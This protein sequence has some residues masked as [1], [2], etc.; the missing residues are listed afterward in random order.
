MSASSS[1]SQGT[2]AP[3]S[4]VEYSS[5]GTSGVGTK[6]SSFFDEL[7]EL[8]EVPPGVKDRSSAEQLCLLNVKDL[9]RK[10]ALRAPPE[11]QQQ[12]GYA[13]DVVCKKFPDGSIRMLLDLNT[14]QPELEYLVTDVG[15]LHIASRT[16][17]MTGINGVTSRVVDISSPFFRT[18]IPNADTLI[19]EALA[20]KA[21][22]GDAWLD[23]YDKEAMHL[24]AEATLRWRKDEQDENDVKDVESRDAANVAVT[25][26]LLFLEERYKFF[27][28]GKVANEAG[29]KRK[30]G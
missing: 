30:R 27:L 23:D 20:T 18:H 9:Q 12:Q 28:N 10:A 2:T 22:T 19:Q 16:L 26:P 5:D 25:M 8:V 13:V 14:S 29:G 3:S 11:E 4:P 1:F 7:R 21:T 6:P 15:Y 17:Y 24:A